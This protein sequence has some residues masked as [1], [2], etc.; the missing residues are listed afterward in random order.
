MPSAAR[1]EP[2]VVRRF[3]R[4]GSDP[5]DEVDWELRDARIVKPDGQV[6]FEQRD[7]EMPAFWSQTATNVVVSK[8]FRGHVGT[9]QRESSVRQLIGRVVG[10]ITSWGREQGHLGSEEEAETFR[11]EL[12]HLLLHQKASFNSPVWFNVGVEPKPQCS[13][14]FILSVQD[15]MVSILELARTEGT[16]FKWGSGAGS[17]LSPLR[18]SQ[19]KLAGGGTASGPVS[20][21]RGFD[22]FAGVIKSGGK[23]RRA[24][25]MVI[26]DVDHPDVL[27]FIRCKAQEEKKAHSL[28]DAGY[29]GSFNVAGGAYETIAYQNANHSVRVTDEFMQAV[30]QDGEWALKAVTVGEVLARHQARALLREMAEAAWVCGDPGIQYDTTI[31]RWHTCAQ[32]GRIRSSN[33]CSEYMFLDDSACNLASLNLMA[34]C[35]PDGEFDAE[36]FCHAVRLLIY[37]QD[38]LVD[39]ASYPTEQIATSSHL[40]R[41]LGLGY[42]N[43][44]ALLMARGLPYDSAAG[45]SVAAALT[46]LMHGEALRASARMARQLGPFARYGANAGDYQQV[47]EQ[48]RRAVDAIDPQGVPVRLFAHLQAVWRALAGEQGEGFR[49]AQVTLLAPTGTIGFM[50]DC[51]TTG[52]EPELSLVRYKTLV[53]G[54]MMK[55]VNQVVPRALKQLG[56]GVAAIGKILEHMEAQGTIEGAPQLRAAHLPVFDCALK[57]ASGERSIEPMG[58]LRMMAAVQPFLSGAISK[59]VNLPHEAT[60]EEIEQIYIAGWKMGL[61]AVAVYRDGCKRT[62]PLSTSD[63]ASKKEGSPPAPAEGPAPAP[64]RARRPLPSERSSITHKFEVGGHSG[65]LTVGMYPDGSP[66]EIFVVMAKQGSTIGGLMDAFATAISIALQ[67]GVPLDDLIRKF[68]HVRFEPS[69]FTG[70]AEI[71]FAKSIVDYIF[72]WMAYRFDVSEGELAQTELPL[73]PAEPEATTGQG[74]R[75]DSPLPRRGPRRRA[76]DLAPDAA[77]GDDPRPAEARGS[78][79]RLVPGT[80]GQA[81]EDAPL[82]PDC[83]SLTVRNGTC[84]KCLNC[85]SSLGCS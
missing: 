20:F 10:T 23:T 31:N 36:G 40:F 74:T 54:G 51:D 21:M 63:Q 58:H 52:I 59:T 45:R 26:L 35:G 8:Y 82:C 4:P 22:A 34:F 46:A 68:S 28:I 30:E 14:C 75:Q 62:Q 43:L 24:A 61:K 16:I 49:N 55:L 2:L 48:H 1:G 72:R 69:G 6:V 18:G 79:P 60:A 70:N 19:E 53:G 78:S 64:R 27:D 37:A 67:Y 57:P 77:G 25:K 83:G 85:G 65:Y 39:R 9:V 33:P 17:N 73:L 71:P 41:P 44:G 38:I 56:Y 15:S 66:G 32:S 12:T 76:S 50:M 42:A 80:A 3:T 84:Y 81:Q 29:D 7:V 11:A 5:F 47:V 13:A